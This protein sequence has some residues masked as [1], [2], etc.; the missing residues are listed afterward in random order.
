MPADPIKKK[1]VDTMLNIHLSKQAF[2]KETS[3]GK[4]VWWDGNSFDTGASS[5]TTPLLPQ[6]R[7][8]RHIEEQYTDEDSR[9]TDFTEAIQDYRNALSNGIGCEDFAYTSPGR[10]YRPQLDEMMEALEW[11]YADGEIDPKI[12]EALTLSSPDSKRM[13]L[14]IPSFIHLI[15]HLAIETNREFVFVI[16][17]FGSDIPRIIPAFQLIA[18]GKHPLLPVAQ[19]IAHPSWE[20]TLRHQSGTTSHLLNLNPLGPSTNPSE[21]ELEINGG[22]EILKFLNSLPN[23]SVIMINDVYDCWR[24]NQKNPVFG[25]PIFIDPLD[26]GCM[27][28]LFDDNVNLNPKD[29]IACV[30]A[31]SDG[32]ISPY[33]LPLDTKSG[34]ATIGTVLLQANMYNSIH[35]RRAFIDE[36]EKAE[37]RFF[38]LKYRI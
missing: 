4:F 30:W 15:R 36:L 18:D 7:Y 1:H 2:V 25:K 28:F 3:N 31:V 6:L 29:S 5:P 13:H 22:R 21:E 26:N 27:H 23:R 12:T 8:Q 10:I 11:N 17:T 32:D 37:K 9:Y 16:R 20:G 38:S 14:F 35:N 33:P 34:L 24:R 19:C